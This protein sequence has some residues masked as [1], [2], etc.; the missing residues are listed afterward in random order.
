[1]AKDVLTGS[2]CV[3]RVSVL[4]FA[5]SGS[6]KS[7]V[8]T[9]GLD[10]EETMFRVPLSKRLAYDF[11]F[12]VATDMFFVRMFSEREDPIFCFGVTK[13]KKSNFPRVMIAVIITP[14]TSRELRRIEKNTF[15]FF[16]GVFSVRSDFSFLKNAS[17]ILCV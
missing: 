2:C 9:A 8:T 17:S 10:F 5:F 4:P 15:F 13:I 16:N 7:R 14:E 3:C 12:C 11:R 6:G 1:M